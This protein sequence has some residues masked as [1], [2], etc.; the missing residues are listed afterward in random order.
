MKVEMPLNK[1]DLGLFVIRYG[2]R[3][4]R[5]V[6]SCCLSEPLFRLSASWFDAHG[7]GHQHLR[8]NLF[9]FFQ[10]VDN[11]VGNALDEQWIVI[12][13]RTP[14]NFFSSHLLTQLF[15][16]LNVQFVERFN[17]VIDKS[18]GYKHQVLLA[19]FD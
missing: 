5:V 12:G 4:R 14:A 3:R 19:S 2:L 10:M 7:A 13:Y 17:M 6:K 1:I 9:A 18:N 15:G 8:I 16:V 11:N